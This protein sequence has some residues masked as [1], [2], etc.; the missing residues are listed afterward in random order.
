MNT[1]IPT[2]EPPPNLDRMTEEGLS[3]IIQLASSD[4]YQYPSKL[5]SE[6]FPRRP[7]GHVY[8]AKILVTYATLRMAVIHHTREGNSR[9]K[10]EIEN[11]L[12][13]LYQNLPRYARW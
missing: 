6:L 1:R 10:D 13:G 9:A 4:N 12:K 7:R 3:E 11:Q 2:R 5:A 8:A